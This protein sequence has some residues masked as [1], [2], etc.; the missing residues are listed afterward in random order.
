MFTQRTNQ[1]VSQKNN[2]CGDIQ[3]VRKE[4]S[5]LQMEVSPLACRHSCGQK[6]HRTTFACTRTFWQTPLISFLKLIVSDLLNLSARGSHYIYCHF[7]N[8]TCN[9]ESRDEI[10]VINLRHTC[11][12]CHDELRNCLHRTEDENRKF[13]PHWR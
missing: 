12:D 5:G 13:K 4:N 11:D 2:L 3:A 9:A 1:Q 6:N 7:K 8:N 10:A